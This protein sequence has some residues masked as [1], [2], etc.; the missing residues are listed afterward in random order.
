M[1]LVQPIGQNI[2]WWV[3]EKDGV[4]RVVRKEGLSTNPRAFTK[5]VRKEFEGESSVEQAER[6]AKDQADGDERAYVVLANDHPSDVRERR[7]TDSQRVSE[8]TS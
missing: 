8:S 4:H 6:Y 5:S 7:I 1:I 2:E 3:R